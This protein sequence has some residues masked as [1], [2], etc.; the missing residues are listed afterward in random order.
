[1]R[2]QGGLSGPSARAARQT[3]FPASVPLR[4]ACLR[5]IMFVVK[6]RSFVTAEER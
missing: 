4:A 5:P 6:S 1:M 3:A 2:V